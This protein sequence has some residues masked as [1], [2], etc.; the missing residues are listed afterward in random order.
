MPPLDT[1]RYGNTI[2]KICLKGHQ[3]GHLQ[4]CP[5]CW[6][7]TGHWV[8]QV[9]QVWYCYKLDINCYQQNLHN[10]MYLFI[11][12]PDIKLDWICQ[13]WSH[14]FC[15]ILLTS[16]FGFYKSALLL[17]M[18]PHCLWYAILSFILQW[19]RTLK[20]IKF[21]ISYC[22]PDC[23]VLWQSMILNAFLNIIRIIINVNLVFCLHIENTNNNN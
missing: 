19:R 16:V 13:S 7:S 12:S 21:I 23:F 15:T 8:G 20:M 10:Y 3:R 22:K 4:Y 5:K 11:G 17:V 9:S 14:V 6:L 18:E 2:N 1:G